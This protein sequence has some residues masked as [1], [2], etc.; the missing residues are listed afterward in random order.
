MRRLL[1]TLTL[2]LSTWLGSPP[3]PVHSHG[4]MH[5]GVIR[6]LAA[7]AA[8]VK[9]FEIT[10]DRRGLNGEREFTITVNQGDTV[11]ITFVYGDGDLAED[12]PHGMAVV[13]YDVQ[14]LVNKANPTATVE[15]IAHRSGTFRIVCTTPCV[16][17]ENLLNGRLEVAPAAPGAAATTLALALT[18]TG[19]GELEAEAALQDQEGK[20]VTGVPVAFYLQTAFGGRMKVGESHTDRRGVATLAYQA[21]PGQVVRLEAVFGGS[22][23]LQ[24]SQATASVALSAGEAPKPPGSLITPYPPLVPTLLLILVVSGVWLTYGFV[25]YQLYRIKVGA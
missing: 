19:A 10:V 8:Q 24:A 21:A 6:A 14:A 17:M 11:R 20:P 3:L 5:L 15:F 2:L 16:G 4:S 1:M 9:S 12:N 22:T 18:P 7:P 25:L 23:E 13:G